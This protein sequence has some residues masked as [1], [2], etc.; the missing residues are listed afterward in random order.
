MLFGVLQILLTLHVSMGAFWKFS[1]LAQSIP[2]LAVIPP[3]V[4]MILI[5]L[6]ILCSLALGIPGF[7]KSF[8]N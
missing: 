1:H 6:E 2:S 5:I 4:W 3:G 8:T 7:I